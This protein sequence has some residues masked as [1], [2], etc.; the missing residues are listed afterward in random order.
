MVSIAPAMP[1]WSVTQSSWFS[2]TDT[3]VSMGMLRSRSHAIASSA[4]PRVSRPCGIS[5]TRSGS[6]SLRKSRRFSA[7]AIG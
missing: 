4:R 7:L 2:N 5:T 3:G 6:I 1:C